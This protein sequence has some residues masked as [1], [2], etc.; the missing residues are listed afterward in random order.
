M[1]VE[2]LGKSIELPDSWAQGY[3]ENFPEFTELKK[4]LEE[5]FL[6]LF[7]RKINIQNW[8]YIFKRALVHASTRIH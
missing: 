6:D 2:L 4:L 5:E 8:D 3:Q 1:K 7:D